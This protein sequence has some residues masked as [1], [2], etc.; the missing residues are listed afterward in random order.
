M[1][2]ASQWK[3]NDQHNTRWGARLTDVLGTGT[4]TTM[5]R[6]Y[7][8]TPPSGELS[9]F[10]ILPIGQRPSST[11]KDPWIRL[12]RAKKSLHPFKS[13]QNG[14]FS[15][16]CCSC[17]APL[18]ACSFQDALRSFF[19]PIKTEDPRLDFYMM[20]KREATDYDTNYVKKYDEDLNTTL[21]FVRS[22][23]SVPLTT[24]SAPVG[25]SVLRS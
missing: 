22:L 4:P 19:Q 5:S 9:A 15:M 21:I 18:T 24:S 23:S 20:Y 7:Q 17:R 11:F 6:V 16:S 13:I 2:P 3:V 14:M 10:F 12:T 1:N 8:D 25:R